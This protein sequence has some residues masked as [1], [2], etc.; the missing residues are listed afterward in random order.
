MI[1]V[2][3]PAT[4]IVSLPEVKAHLRV[5]HAHEDALIQAY[6]DAATSWIDGFDGV[7]GRCVL[8]QTWR[9]SAVEAERIIAPY[10]TLLIVV[11]EDGTVDYTCAMPAEKVPSVKAAILLLVGYWYEQRQASV[12][13]NW[14]EAPLAV[15]SLL[16][17]LRIWA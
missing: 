14:S 17:P 6:L 7:L 2:T 8:E 9:A 15:K 13:G 4:A 11:N 3:P 1:R 16:A 12:E 5:D 10:D